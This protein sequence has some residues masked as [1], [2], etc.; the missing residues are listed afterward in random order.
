M[1][2]GNFREKP[3]LG[4]SRLV[5]TWSG[6]VQSGPVLARSGQILGGSAETQNLRTPCR[7]EKTCPVG[8]AL[9]HQICQPKYPSI[10]Y[11]APLQKSR[12][13]GFSSYFLGPPEIAKIRNFGFF[14][15]FSGDPRN[16][17]NPEFPGFP[18]NPG[19]P[20]NLGIPVSAASRLDLIAKISWQSGRK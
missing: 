6:P 17:E 8:E 13:S 3:T 14:Q 7:F 5:R 1:K 10:K 12:I 15:L 2:I 4:G 16:R 20:E 18:G 9:G 11:R 19:F